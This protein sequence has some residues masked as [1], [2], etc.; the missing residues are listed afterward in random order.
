VSSKHVGEDLKDEEYDVQCIHI[1]DHDLEEDVEDQR[2]REVLH[3]QDAVAGRRV[4]PI[5]DYEAGEC[6]IGNR[7]DVDKLFEC[8]KVVD[9]V[10]AAQFFE[11]E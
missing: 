2:G 8:L 10:N 11:Y 9:L 4:E 6:S 7:Y 5:E 3:T 1:S